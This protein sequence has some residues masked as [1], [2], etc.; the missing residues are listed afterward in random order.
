MEALLLQ[1]HIHIPQ[2]L[3]S[4][5]SITASGFFFGVGL[6]LSSVRLLNSSP[7]AAHREL[8]GAGRDAGGVQELQR[9]PDT[10]SP[11]LGGCLFPFLLAGMPQGAAAS[12][13]HQFTAPSFP[14]PGEAAAHGSFLAA[15]QQHA[16]CR[17]LPSSCCPLGVGIRAEPPPSSLVPAPPVSPK[18]FRGSQ[19]RAWRA[20]GAHPGAG[21]VSTA[22]LHAC[23]WG[24]TRARGSS[25]QKLDLKHQM[26]SRW[27][28]RPPGLPQPPPR[29]G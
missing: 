9:H 29:W 2:Q 22:A 15:P 7:G 3:S 13:L 6:L 28:W 10:T 19:S 24:C 8:P 21:A 11:S 17:G 14:V 27:G 5:L 25:R 1:R 4:A 23:A 12:F 16:G 18:C 26:S 20:V